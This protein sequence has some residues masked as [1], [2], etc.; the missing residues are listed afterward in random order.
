MSKALAPSTSCGT[1][2]NLLLRR[3]YSL[4]ITNVSMTPSTVLGDREA[5]GLD[6]ENPDQAFPM[7]Q[8]FLSF[9][10]LLIWEKCSFF[11]LCRQGWAYFCRTQK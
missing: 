6:N 5:T 11:Q 4:A 8:V 9:E 1:K 10:A 7:Q 2:E 3:T